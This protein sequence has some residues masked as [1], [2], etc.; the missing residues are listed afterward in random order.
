MTK[1]F[2]ELS[3]DPKFW[4]ELEK[5]KLKE[6]DTWNKLVKN[7]KKKLKV[8]PPKVPGSQWRVLAHRSNGDKLDFRVRP[9]HNLIFDELVLDCAIHLEQMDTRNWWM[10][11]GDA[12]VWITIPKKGEPQIMIERGQY[13]LCNNKPCKHEK[14]KMGEFV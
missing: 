10:Q 11:L 8:T 5:D 14:A 7:T 1:K 9:K 6:Q 2:K 12:Y 13:C 4:K 3:L